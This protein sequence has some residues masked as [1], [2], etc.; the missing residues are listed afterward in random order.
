M[1]L[2]EFKQSLKDRIPLDT[3]E[4]FRVLDR[5]I[6]PERSIYNNLKLLQ[7][8]FSDVHADANRGTLD[9]ENSLRFKTQVR[10]A[11]I[12][13]IDELKAEDLL[14]KK[15]FRI[16]V[17]CRNENDKVYMEQYFEALP[18]DATVL[19]PLDYVEPDGYSLLVF[20][21]HSIGA[22]PKEEALKNLPAD[23]QQF[24]DLLLQYLR[25]A[26]KWLVYFGE[27]NY[28]VNNFRDTTNAANN[29]FSLYARIKEMKDFME[30]YQVG[31]KK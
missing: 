24:M 30:E 6:E 23:V 11:L 2:P 31:R 1:A 9:Y 7:S 28:L 22:V 12:E 17:I 19:Q 26:P 10:Q 4:V 13:L 14:K 20:D 5:H 8:R 16:L 29:K 25:N 18:L 3:Q 15:D 27:L 21:A